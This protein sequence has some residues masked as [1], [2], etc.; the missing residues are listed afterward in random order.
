MRMRLI[1]PGMMREK[2]CLPVHSGFGFK[3]A[4]WGTLPSQEGSHMRRFMR[5]SWRRGKEEGEGRRN[6]RGGGERR[7]R[8]KRRGKKIEGGRDQRE[9]SE[10]N[11]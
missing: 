2:S 9:K 1:M 7:V 8:R 5:S 4:G 3:M 11:I 10:E 6:G